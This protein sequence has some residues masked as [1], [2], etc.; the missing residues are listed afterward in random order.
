MT[1]EKTSRL[2]AI[3]LC[4]ILGII[5]LVI[6]LGVNHT[7]D[8]GA[9]DTEEQ[10]LSDFRADILPPPMFLV[11]S[12]A[13]A[14]I[15]TLHRDAY[16]INEEKLA[17]LEQQYWDADRK[18]AQS[19][20]DDSLK[21]GLAA[22]V[23]ANGKAFWD[24]INQRLK[25]AARRWDQDAMLASHRRLL[26]IYRAHRKANEDLVAQSEVLSAAVADRNA[27]T[28]A[29]VL[30]GSALAVMLLSAALLFAY[31][32]VRRGMLWPM[33][34]TADTMREMA[35]GNF[36]SGITTEHRNDEIGTMTRAIETFR[37]ALKS[38]KSRAIAQTEIV[39]TLST[40]LD[41]LA[42]G[43]LTYRIA[44][45]PEVV[46]EEERRSKPRP[47]LREMYNT[48]VARLETMI[49]A[50]HAT[51]GS[52]RTGSDE[53]RAASEDLALRNEQQAASLEE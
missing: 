46:V 5:V 38:D 4:G 43:D 10:R 14:S 24:E 27:T 25:P 42:Q 51:V 52:V 16:A 8:G 50:V 22:N 40:A 26:A 31:L 20:L 32:W 35:A 11:E 30:I 18:W 44:T 37:A 15:M 7:R 34:A 19:A 39:E 45:L 53:I 12:F 21:A 47:N 9:L 28:T 6:G 17:K 29:M 2:G 3:A 33:S 48:S 36:D 23:R 13:N 1:I 41:R 49:G